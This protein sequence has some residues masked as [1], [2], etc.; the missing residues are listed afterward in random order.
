MD[1]E[2][3]S[4]QHVYV[5]LSLRCLSVAEK[6]GSRVSLCSYHLNTPFVHHLCVPV[7]AC[8]LYASMAAFSKTW[9]F[10]SVFSFDSCL[11]LEACLKCSPLPPSSWHFSEAAGPGCEEVPLCRQLALQDHRTQTHGGSAG[12]Q[13]ERTKTAHC[14]QTTHC[15]Q[16]HSQADCKPVKRQGDMWGSYVLL[17]ITVNETLARKQSNECKFLMTF[18]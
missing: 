18:D 3:V 17:C 8:K 9:Q 15:C 7:C 10:V 6:T 2:P 1:V 5:P 11:P 12:C 14:Q 4:V 16:F 13:A